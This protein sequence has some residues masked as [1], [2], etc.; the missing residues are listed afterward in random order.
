MKVRGGRSLVG[1]GVWAACLGLNP[2]MAAA[3]AP[4]PTVADGALDQERV[5]LSREII[6]LAYPVE[7]REGLFFGTMD[8]LLAQ[9]R[10]AMQPSLLN[11]RAAL[12][13]VNEAVDRMIASGKV[14][15]ARR[16]PGIMEAY[17]KAYA[18]EFSREE[19]LV[20]RDF[21]R[22]P[23]GRH[24]MARSTA[25]LNDPDFKAQNQDYIRELMPLV[26]STQKELRERLIQHFRDHPPAPSK[27]T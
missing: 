17:A 25:I 22:T 21:V 7:T 2:A 6:A 5:Q 13:I 19:L 12:A 20:L 4:V 18:R 27:R 14:I 8:S 26:E 23:T 10:G 9:M 1:F 15:L 16:I 24:F 3:P 11:D